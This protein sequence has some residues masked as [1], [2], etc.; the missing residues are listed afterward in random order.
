MVNKR[1]RYELGLEA[2]SITSHYLISIGY[3]ILHKRWKSKYGEIDIVAK[4]HDT[5]LFVEVKAKKESRYEQEMV[6]M[7]QRKRNSKAALDFLGQ[8]DIN[9][10]LNIRFDCAIVTNKKIAHYI[11]NA[12]YIENEVYR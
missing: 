2:E 6:S 3:I 10:S 12:W 11:E 9:E 4:S 7:R 1:L 5:I 8:S